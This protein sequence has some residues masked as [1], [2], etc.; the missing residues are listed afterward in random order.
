[1][2]YDI[3]LTDDDFDRLEN[4]V[5]A[6]MTLYENNRDDCEKYIA[7]FGYKDYIAAMRETWVARIEMAKS[8]LLML[9][10]Q[11]LAS[12]QKMRRVAA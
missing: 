11:R 2:S 1:M 12:L 8:T 3:T 5:R 6:A 4:C 7:E 9:H 10:E